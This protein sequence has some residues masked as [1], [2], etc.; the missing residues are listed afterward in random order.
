[1]DKVKVVD[2]IAKPIDEKNKRDEKR[3]NRLEG[4]TSV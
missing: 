2:I 1:M 4:I 3:L